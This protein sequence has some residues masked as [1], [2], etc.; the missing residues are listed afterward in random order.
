MG[1]YSNNRFSSTTTMVDYDAI[2]EADDNYNAVTGCAMVFLESQQN[3]FL[4]P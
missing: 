2:T 3:D 4:L 1:I